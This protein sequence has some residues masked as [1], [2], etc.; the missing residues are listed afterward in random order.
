MDIRQIPIAID[1]FDDYF[2]GLWIRLAALII[3][4]LILAPFFIVSAIFNCFNLDSYWYTL[5]IGFVIMCIYQIYLP[6]RFGGTPGKLALSLKIIKSDGEDLD[7]N[8]AFM[9]YLPMLLLGLFQLSIML[10]AVGKADS[11]EFDATSWMKQ[12]NYLMGYVS[13]SYGVYS[14]ITCGWFISEII[15][16]FANLRKQA[17][18]DMIGGTV[19]IKKGEDNKIKTYMR[20]LPPLNDE[21]MAEYA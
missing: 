11:D 18:H 3:D 4:C 5:P 14:W 2:A 7:W 1:R 20:S 17:V 13:F 6:K 21:P 10:Y 19:V 15:V 12:N 8:A 16:V 9:R